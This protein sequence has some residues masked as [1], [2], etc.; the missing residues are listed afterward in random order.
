MLFRCILIFFPPPAVLPGH[1]MRWKWGW[2][3]LSTCI[4]ARQYGYRTNKHRGDT[5]STSFKS[6]LT[7]SITSS[8][9][10][11]PF[12]LY[13][14]YRSPSTSCL[15]PSEAS[16]GLLFDWNHTYSSEIKE[17][18][19]ELR[20]VGDE[21]HMVVLVDDASC[22]SNRQIS[23]TLWGT[24]HFS[25]QFLSDSWKQPGADG[26]HWYHVHDSNKLCYISNRVEAVHAVTWR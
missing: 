10:N 23:G 17:M 13:K 26:R 11:P 1:C 12:P 5:H 4:S 2:L 15:N 18:A 25:R 6:F 9:C 14:H 3:I 8:L 22:F 21:R 24:T 19:A 16:L 7:F 20:Q